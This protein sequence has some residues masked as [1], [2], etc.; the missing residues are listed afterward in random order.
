[1]LSPAAMPFTHE[2][3]RFGVSA[4]EMKPSNSSD[5]GSSGACS[6]PESITIT[7][8]YPCSRKHRASS[9]PSI[10]GISWSRMTTSNRRRRDRL[11]ASTPEPA[12]VTEKPAS[13]NKAARACVPNGSSSTIRMGARDSFKEG[14]A[15]HETQNSGEGCSFGDK[16][17]SIWT[18]LRFVLHHLAQSRQLR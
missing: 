14:C 7:E 13:S 18:K 3:K 16:I 9:R 5:P 1:M 11:R 6:L 4:L 2:T 12:I 10:P 17:R 8:V 15:V